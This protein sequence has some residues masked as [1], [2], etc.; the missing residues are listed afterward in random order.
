MD[1]PLLD[2]K[3]MDKSSSSN[4]VSSP[5][6]MAMESDTRQLSVRPVLHKWSWR[7]ELVVEVEG[8]TEPAIEFGVEDGM[9]VGEVGEVGEIEAGE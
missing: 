1:I 5:C 7:R 3:F 6:S 9:E 2:S 4:V 8:E